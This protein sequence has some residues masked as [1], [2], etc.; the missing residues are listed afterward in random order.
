[1][2]IIKYTAII[3]ALAAGTLTSCKNAG[4]DFPDYQGGTTVSFA[5]QYPVRTLVMGED[6]YDTSVD[7]AHACDIYA[8]MGGAYK[9]RDITL[10]IA[11]DNSLTD[12][13]TFDGTTPV[14]AMPESYYTLESNKIEFKGDYMGAVRVKFTDAFFNDPDALKNTYV[15][16][17]VIKGQKGA[18]AILAGTPAV[19]GNQ[20]PRTLSS[21]W[22]VQPKDFV[23]YCVKYINKYHAEY[24]TRGLDKI[25]ENGQT[26]TNV[27]HARYVEEDELRS[28]H[29]RNLTTAV[30]PVST[31]I[32][33]PDG[34]KQTLKC[35]LLLSFN[36]NDECTVSTDTPG[37][38]ASGTGKF[39][40]K[41]DKNSWGG[42]DRNALYLE[43][44]V[45]FGQ[46]RMQTFDTLVVKSR[47][48]AYET[49]TPEY[50]Q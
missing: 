43:Y 30:Y 12:N 17:I 47:N 2:K 28:V 29:T 39:V 23:L 37:C 46:R 42:K 10:D 16:P 36:D 5:R 1:M 24:A 27:R 34:N 11:V 19:E 20:P 26:T 4:Q 38:T 50:I 40:L 3:A 14:K 48:V 35:D 8:T 15:V 18:D 25:T 44:D 22:S 9:G 41:G 6:T 49:F 7:N 21:A 32:T 13:L 45:D 33:L 31:V